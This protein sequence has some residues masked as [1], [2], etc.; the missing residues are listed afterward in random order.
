MHVFPTRLEAAGLDQLKAVHPPPGGML[1]WNELEAGY[2]AFEET[3]RL[4]KVRVDN[5]SKVDRCVLMDKAIVGKDC[6]LRNVILDKNVVVPDGATLG[7]DLELD[8]ARGYYVSDG[9]VDQAVALS[10][11]SGSANE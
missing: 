5:G 10:T 3:R 11:A 1:L 7:V 9:G 6:E 2:R 4:P 8:R